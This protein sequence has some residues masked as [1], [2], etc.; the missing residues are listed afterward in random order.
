MLELPAKPVWIVADTDVQRP[1][2]PTRMMDSVVAA[3]P[4]RTATRAECPRSLPD[5]KDSPGGLGGSPEQRPLAFAESV[6]HA[7]SILSVV[8][9][10]YGVTV[11]AEPVFGLKA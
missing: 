7:R 4:R 5:A 8:V 6:V 3:S 9:T 11:R 10:C 1:V 2:G